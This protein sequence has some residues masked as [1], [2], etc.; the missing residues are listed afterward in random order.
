MNKKPNESC[1]SQYFALLDGTKVMLT[2][3]QFH[4]WKK[5]IYAERNNAHRTGS[6]GQSDY[7]RCSGDCGMCRWARNG[8]NVHIDSSAHANEFAPGVISHSASQFS[9]EDYV[10]DKLLSISIYR[11]AGSIV[12]RGDAILFHYAEE[13]LS[14]VK[15]AECLGIPRETVRYR[16]NVL[17]RKLREDYEQLFGA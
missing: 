9:I 11:Y 4:A 7:R 15:I 5:T 13:G 1:E 3:E 2:E 10:V 12:P 16:L 8:K 14:V 17:L 6:C